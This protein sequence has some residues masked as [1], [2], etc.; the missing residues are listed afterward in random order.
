MQ[1]FSV[2]YIYMKQE[3]FSLNEVSLLRVS[4]AECWSGFT[5]E[6]LSQPFPLLFLPHLP[7]PL[8]G[9]RPGV[10]R[11]RVAAAGLS[12]SLH[13]DTASQ[14]DRDTGETQRVN[15]KSFLVFTNISSSSLLPLAKLPNLVMS[16]L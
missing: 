14:G 12:T 16:I 5:G 11:S 15:Q 7:S 9:W 6:L 8:A 3:M 10:C 13:R 2:E 4:G 1:V